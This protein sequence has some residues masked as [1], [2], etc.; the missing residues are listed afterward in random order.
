MGSVS[1]GR[2]R[3]APDRFAERAP[4]MLQSPVRGSSEPIYAASYAMKASVNVSLAAR[5]MKRRIL[6]LGVTDPFSRSVARER[7]K[8]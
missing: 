6:G 8:S 1:F 4:A 3:S 5:S 7:S 2:F